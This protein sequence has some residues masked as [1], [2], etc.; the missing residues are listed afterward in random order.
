[1]GCRVGMSTDPEERIRYWKRVE[2]HT[3]GRVISKGLT[4]REAQT[5][6]EE[7]ARSGGCVHAAGG[8]H[9]A[10]RV[11]SVYKVSGGRTS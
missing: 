1:M 4:Y 2:G 7:A 5:K 6:E 10:G 9:K 3:S 11:W 8:E